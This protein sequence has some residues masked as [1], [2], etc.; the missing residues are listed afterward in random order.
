MEKE[1]IIENALAQIE[2]AFGKGSIMKLGDNGPLKDIEYLSLI[3][4]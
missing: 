3:H 2:R 4:I 1:K